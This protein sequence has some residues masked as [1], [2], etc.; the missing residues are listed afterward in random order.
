[1]AQTGDL[2]GRPAKYFDLV[3]V[4]FV[5]ALLVSNVA[6]QKLF[7]FG[8]F[9]FTAGILIFPIS[10]IFGD[11]LTEVY[12]YARA[13][14]VI[15]AGFGA[16]LFMV[17]VIQAAIA[18]PPAEGWPFQE[19][20]EAVL[21]FVPRIVLASVLAY[22]AGEFSN[23]Y[24]LA[25]MKIW[26]EGRHLWMRTIGSTVVGQG[27]DTA[28]FTLVAFVGVLP[29]AVIIRTIISGYIFKVVYEAVV[30]PVTYLIVGRLKRAEGIDVYDRDTDFTPFSFGPQ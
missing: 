4:T 5:V 8:P 6:A 29:N 10:Y 20:F 2:L 22:W 7:A 3:A 25:K 17:L 13:R 9:T 12:G 19:Q 26:A 18:L 27:I 15:W 23:S 30:T 24:V 21:G 14:R 16:N 11:I 1:M 28:I